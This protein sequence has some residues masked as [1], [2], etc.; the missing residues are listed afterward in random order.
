M[1]E[2][3]GG[4]EDLP[5]RWLLSQQSKCPHVTQHCLESSDRSAEPKIQSQDYVESGG[6]CIVRA[7]PK[8]LKLL[9]NKANIEFSVNPRTFIEN[10]FKEFYDSLKEKKKRL[11]SSI[12]SFMDILIFSM[13]FIIKQAIPE[14]R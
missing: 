8:H 9:L 1:T 3:P 4:T 7:A 6:L 12:D 5:V 10:S 2:E 13:C 11:H 14:N